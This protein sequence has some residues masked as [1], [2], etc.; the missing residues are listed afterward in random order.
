MLKIGYVSLL[1]ACF[2]CAVPLKKELTSHSSNMRGLHAVDKQTAW[3]S[4]TQAVILEL[5]NGETWDQWHG[6]PIEEFISLDFRDVHGFNANEAIIMSSGDGCKIFRTSD[7]GM[8][9]EKV[10]ENM[11]EGIFF[12]GMDFWDNKRGMAF[13]DPIDGKLFLIKT[14]DGGKSWSRL[15]PKMLPDVMEKEAGFAASG[16]GIVCKGDSTVWIATGGGDIA[17]IFK[18]IDGGM[19]WKVYE[20]PIKTDPN[21]YRGIYSMAMKDEL[22]GIVIGGSFTDSAATD[23]ICAFTEDGGVSWHLSR[24]MPTGYRSC[25]AYL[26]KNT[27]ICC[28]RNGIDVS[29]DGGLNWLNVS[30]EA[31]YSTARVGEKIWFIGKKGKRASMRLNYI[32]RLAPRSR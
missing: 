13:S 7:G 24:T 8:N 5:N 6:D 25:V 31:Y 20:T 19:N 1:I 18:S 23:N 10:Y 27:Y 15:I 22:H 12:D 9:W 32:R 3:A 16:T 30:T 29:F 17:R 26:E 28:G 14:V 4:G 2:S 21:K 11:N